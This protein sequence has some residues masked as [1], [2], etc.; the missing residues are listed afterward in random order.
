VYALG[1]LAVELLT[2]SEMPLENTFWIGCDVETG[3]LR[4]RD[5][6]HACVELKTDPERRL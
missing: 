2:G 6:R 1:Y 4:S 3:M 5:V